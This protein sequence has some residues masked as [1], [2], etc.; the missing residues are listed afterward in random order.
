MKNTKAGTSFSQALTYIKLP[1]YTRSWL[2][3]KYGEVLTLHPHSELGQIMQRYLVENKS[4][5]KLSDVA[6]T[7]TQYDLALSEHVDAS[8]AIDFPSVDVA[9][10]LL[11]VRMPY[12]LDRQGLRL[13]P[14]RN[15]QLAPRGAVAFR[16]ECKEMFF[17]CLIRYIEDERMRMREMGAEF[18]IGKTI[19]QFS[20]A[21]NISPDQSENLERYVRREVKDI[22]QKRQARAEEFEHFLL[23]DFSASKKIVK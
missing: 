13:H 3:T 19:D 12:E 14:S 16:K 22:M 2:V 9:R 5:K 8:S 18:H 17:D 10:E 15:W 11:A 21:Y 20:F 6:Y 23:G 4:L 1:S 7:Q